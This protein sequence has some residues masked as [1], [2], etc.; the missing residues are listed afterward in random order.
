MLLLWAIG[1]VSGLSGGFVNLFL[2]GAI[3]VFVINLCTT[4]LRRNALR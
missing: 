2:A 3:A 4:G 1:S